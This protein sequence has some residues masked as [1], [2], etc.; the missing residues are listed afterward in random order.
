MYGIVG[1]GKSYDFNY[2]QDDN[3][4]TIASYFTSK[5]SKNKN[6]NSKKE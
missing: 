1:F 2:E 6:I 3:E 4:I 5:N